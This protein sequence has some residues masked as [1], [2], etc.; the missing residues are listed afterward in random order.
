MIVRTGRHRRYGDFGI[1]KPTPKPATISDEELMRR[2]AACP[3]DNWDRWC[4]CVWGQEE[5]YRLRCKS[6]PWACC[7]F[8]MCPDWANP[9]EDYGA[10]CRFLYKPGAGIGYG[11][12]AATKTLSLTSLIT[13][14]LQAQD[15]KKKEAEEAAAAAA[16]AAAYQTA[17]QRRATVTDT[18]TSF[19]IAAGVTGAAFIFLAALKRRRSTAATTR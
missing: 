8:S 18:A 4:D 5:E 7:P 1:A 9:W 13:D 17:E 2:W 12:G 6:K 19:A 15:V 16:Q 11:V 10:G 14:P 3:Q